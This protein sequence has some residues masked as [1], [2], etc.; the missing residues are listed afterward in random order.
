[1]ATNVTTRLVLLIKTNVN[2][3]TKEQYY[4]DNCIRKWQQLKL[5]TYN[6]GLFYDRRFVSHKS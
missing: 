4:F 3:S 5:V 2:E 6:Y 1:M